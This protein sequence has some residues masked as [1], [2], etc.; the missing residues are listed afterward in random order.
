[1]KI[2]LT[3]SSITI[4]LAI[5]SRR[6]RNGAGARNRKETLMKAGK[7]WILAP[8]LLALLAA[9]V[10]PEGPTKEDFLSA[11]EHVVKAIEA[12]D[13][14]TFESYFS[15][16]TR[17]LQPDQLWSGA[18]RLLRKFGRIE[19]FEFR[20][21]DEGS[22]G[23][24]VIVTFENAKRDVFVRLSKKTGKIRELTYVPPTNIH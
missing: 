21:M 3:E 20:E 16:N 1:M 5:S 6:S 13:Y 18:T 24:F 10:A 4:R 17:G 22:G 12:E 8:T 19:S 9:T 7:L 15:E 23:A 11:V 2:P 14:E